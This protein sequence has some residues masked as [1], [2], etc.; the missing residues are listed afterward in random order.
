MEILINI[1]FKQQKTVS[2]SVH[3]LKSKT[4]Y[5]KDTIDRYIV[6]YV[7]LIISYESIIFLGEDKYTAYLDQVYAEDI[8]EYLLKIERKPKGVSNIDSL[9]RA[10]AINWLIKINVSTSDLK[11][12]KL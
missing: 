4:R 1:S 8:L 3:Q 11:Q 5:H 9:I 2:K 7:K 6:K 12:S 10:C